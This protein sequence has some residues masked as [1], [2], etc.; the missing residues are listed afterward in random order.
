MLSQP[1]QSG[2][3]IFPDFIM[4]RLNAVKGFSCAGSP[5]RLA[6]I[7]VPLVAQ[8]DNAFIARPG[9][10]GNYKIENAVYS[11]IQV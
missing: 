5:D 9:N 3:K 7:E 11:T 1:V 2:D 10:T 4:V 6:V 8:S